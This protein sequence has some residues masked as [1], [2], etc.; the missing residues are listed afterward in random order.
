MEPHRLLLIPLLLCPLFWNGLWGR[1]SQGER[2]SV[3]S[4]PLTSDRLF[5]TILPVRLTLSLWHCVSRFAAGFFP[6]T[7]RGSAA[8]QEEQL[9]KPSVGLSSTRVC[10]PTATVAGQLVCGETRL[11]AGSRAALSPWQPLRFL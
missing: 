4:D 9:N 11:K 5:S 3:A 10:E 8:S 2:D 7:Q 1:R 6:G